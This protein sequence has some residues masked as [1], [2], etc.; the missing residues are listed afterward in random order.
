MLLFTGDLAS[1]RTAAWPCRT[2]R[3]PTATQHPSGRCD[4]ESPGELVPRP[5]SAGRSSTPAGRPGKAAAAPGALHGA[6]LRRRPAL[7]GVVF[8]ARAQLGQEPQRTRRGVHRPARPLQE[9]ADDYR[10]RT[11]CD[12]ENVTGRGL[13]R[14]HGQRLL[15]AHAAGALTGEQLAAWI[16]GERP[17]LGVHQFSLAGLPGLL[18]AELL[19]ALQRRDQSAPPMDP[20]EIRILLARLDR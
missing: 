18:Q 5:G 19:F 3:C 11:G 20:T 17:R 15:R 1:P 16:A 8:P 4:G 6:R 7:L 9:R 10:V 2:P 14:F 13:C 12:R